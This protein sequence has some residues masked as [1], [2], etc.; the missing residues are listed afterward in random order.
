[1]AKV[2]R[3]PR[4]QVLCGTAADGRPHPPRHLINFTLNPN[5]YKKSIETYDAITSQLSPM[6]VIGYLR[7]QVMKYTMR[8]GDKHDGTIDA[9]IMDIGKADWYLNKLLKYLNDL[10]NDKS[11]IDRP[12]NVA[13]LFKDK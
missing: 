10:K 5:H 4:Q 11:F 12:N 3:R 8:M 9:C 13:E 1:M 7:S 2:V 6:E